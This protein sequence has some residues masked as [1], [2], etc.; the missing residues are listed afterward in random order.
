MLQQRS[1]EW[2]DI[3][4]GKFTASGIH[5]LLG[6]QGLGKTGE[7]Y[8]FELASQIAFGV[9]E[10]ESFESWDM[11]RG[12][13]LEPVAFEKFKGLK[14]L[15]FV[16][17]DEA[18]FFPY[19]EDAGASPDGVTSDGGILEIKCPRSLKF[20]QLV[21]DGVSSIDPQYYS[22]MQ[23]QIMCSNSTHAYFFNYI[24]FN[25]LPKWHEIK[26]ERDDNVIGLIK[27]R[28]P[29]AVKLRNEYTEYLIKNKQF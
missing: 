16:D 27:E 15:D 29:I 10:E 11:K 9:D 18:F 1:K 12:I 13:Q 21:K 25:G 2:F 17:V 23:M 3:R 20:F 8:C 6:K 24:I 7:S 5:N 19:G 4:K 26:V 28:L 14:Y 22:Q